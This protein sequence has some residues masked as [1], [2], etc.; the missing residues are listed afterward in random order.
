MLSWP[1][2]TDHE[3]TQKIIHGQDAFNAKYHQEISWRFGQ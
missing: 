2:S 3:L 1:F